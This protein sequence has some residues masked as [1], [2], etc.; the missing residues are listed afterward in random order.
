MY[1][2][3]MRSP[4]LM[5]FAA[6]CT[7]SDPY[8]VQTFKFGPFTIQPS[9]EVTDQCVQITLHNAQ[10][11]YVSQDDAKTGPGFHQS[12]W[13]YVPEALFAGTDG[14]YKCSDRQFDQAV[15]GARGGVLFAQS[16]Q[17]AHDLQTF[18]E[19]AAIAIPAHFK[20]VS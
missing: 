15:A 13:F 10:E 5:A 1:R 6:A 2:S 8:A 12:N 11:L 20:L 19:G 16:T 14:T 3:R 4:L 7:A 18:P 17:S 9:Q